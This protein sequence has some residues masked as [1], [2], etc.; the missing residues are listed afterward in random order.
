M[1]SPDETVRKLAA[2]IASNAYRANPT[3]SRTRPASLPADLVERYV[4]EVDPTGS[5][6]PRER[7]SRATAAW[8][9][10]LALL[11]LE[12]YKAGGNPQPPAA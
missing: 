4:R 5:L 9:R 3:R 12:V 2:T 10:D 8:R 11:A 7:L 6:P 1:A